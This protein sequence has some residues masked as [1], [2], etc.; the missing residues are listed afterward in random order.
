[1]KYKKRIKKT[2]KTAKLKKKSISKKESAG[3]HIKM[4][5]SAREKQTSSEKVKA[6]ETRVDNLLKK[7]RLRGFITHA[8]ILKEFPLVEEDVVFLDDLYTRFHDANV[9]ILEGKDLLEIS[10]EKT[11]KLKKG[12]RLADLGSYDSVQMYLKEIGKISLLT[13]EEE[14]E[15]ARSIEKGDEEAKNKLAQ[16]NLRLVVSIAKRYINRSPH[17]TILDLIQ[18]GNL[19]LFRAVEK[20]DWRRGYKFSTYATWWIR[21]AITRA[22]ADQASTVRIPV[23]MVETISKYK[24]ITR[25]LSQDLGRDPLAEEIAAE[26]GLDVEKVRHIQKIKQ[27]TISLEAPVGDEDEDS[28]LGEFIEDE[29]ILSPVQQTAQRLLVDQ[30]KEILIDLT[31]R[32]RRILEMR[33]GLNDGVTRTLEEVGKEFGVTRERIRQIEAKALEKIRQHDKAKKLKE[34]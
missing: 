10:D 13:G 27:E 3:F 14:K 20:F 16:A 11:P 23:H 32:E 15:F 33:F 9:D 21:Q 2:K 6:V 19:G 18:E 26:M 7:G 12:R 25:R 1:M 28:T 31:P 34:Y 5:G 17:L 4:I 8:E 30:V 24:Q 22:L 29:K